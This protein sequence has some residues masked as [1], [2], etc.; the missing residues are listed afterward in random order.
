MYKSAV[1]AKL[2][3]AAFVVRGC[4]FM[5]ALAFC[6]ALT[7]SNVTLAWNA[8][9]DPEVQGY[10]CYYGVASRVY[11][12]TIPV[13]NATTVTLTNLPDGLTYYFAATTYNAA[14]VESEYSDEVSFT[15]PEI[16]N[17]GPKATLITNGPG[18]ISPNLSKRQLTAGRTY[19]VTA[20][21]GPGQAFAGWVGSINSSAPT[22]SFVLA[23]NLLLQ[24]NFI[25]S[26]FIP[27]QG[28]YNGLF[29]EPAQ[30]R[31][32]SSGAFSVALSSRG[33]YSGRLQ[34]GSLRLG[35][36]GQLALDCQATNTIHH[37]GAATLVLQL[38]VGVGLQADTISGTLASD[39][40]TA[41]LSGDRAVFNSRTNPLFLPRT[42]TVVFPG[43]DGDPSLPAG[44][45]FGSVRISA[46]G[47]AVL[48]GTLADGTRLAQ[49][50]TLSRQSLWPLYAPLY[51]GQG[52]LLSWLAVTNLN[53]GQLTG[54]AN[55]IKPADARAPYYPAGFNFQSQAFGSV[56][57]PPPDAT[58][59]PLDLPAASVA[60][61]GGALPSSFAD[62]ITLIS[63]SQVVV[64]NGSRLTL[65][66]L[67]S[68]GVF[69]GTV[70]D[71]AGAG[72]YPFA[73]AVLQQLNVGYGLLLHSDQS[74]R[75][76]L[77]P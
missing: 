77:S 59:P 26:P 36:S 9:S 73:G 12:R 52:S 47:L 37:A 60:F 29:F 3:R 35:F 33:S 41:T 23:S 6:P 75:V 43:Q 64:Q 28:A 34:T 32:E 4:G 57:Q 10:N 51:H 22:L 48:A 65:S 50:A 15:L 44:D 25:P 7:A 61:M 55:W 42:W 19:A 8:T 20:R 56:Y 1:F 53:G 46:G 13:G 45:G 40:W 5:G 38:R 70:A 16:G 58:Q 63:A 62:T 11:I 17:S 18:S 54:S 21:P 27:A 30:V 14:G 49:S 39:T 71:P 68:T 74:S 67:P 72:N 2:R 24:A 76:V 69:K 31:Q 66:F